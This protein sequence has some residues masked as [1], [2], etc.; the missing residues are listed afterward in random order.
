MTEFKL[1]ALISRNT[2]NMAIV[3]YI[4]EKIEKNKEKYISILL[5]YLNN[6]TIFYSYWMRPII[7]E[8]L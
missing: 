5:S 3:D 1:Y 8:R 2:K 4:L 7:G 6:D